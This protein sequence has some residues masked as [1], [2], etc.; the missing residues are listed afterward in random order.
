MARCARLVHGL[1]DEVVGEVVVGVG[2][3]TFDPLEGD[4][5]VGGEVDYILDEDDVF[6]AGESVV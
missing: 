1:V 4:F 6:L 3:V 5:A 2:G